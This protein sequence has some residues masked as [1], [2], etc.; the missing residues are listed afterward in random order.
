MQWRI[1][2]NRNFRQLAQVSF[3]IKKSP[4]LQVE[5]GYDSSTLPLHE[6]DMRE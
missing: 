2:P 1:F 4:M 5:L 3:K 6:L